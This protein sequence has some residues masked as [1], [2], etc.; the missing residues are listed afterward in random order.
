M[1][2]VFLL[3]CAVAGLFGAAYGSEF[4]AAAS[5]ARDDAKWAE[6][7]VVAITG[8][9]ERILRRNMRSS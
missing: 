8:H 4:P 1:K 5:K 6:Y 7:D 2:K 3:L 9:D